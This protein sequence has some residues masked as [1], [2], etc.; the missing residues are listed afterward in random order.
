MSQPDK[1]IPLKGLRG[2]IANNMMSSLQQ[3]AQLS[4]MTDV[5]IDPLLNFRKFYKDKGI[6]IGVED[7]LLKCVSQSL[8]SFP[9][10]NGTVEQGEIRLKENQAISIATPIAGGL[11]APK[12]NNI[13]LLSLEEISSQRRDL[14]SRA[15]N[16]QLK[17]SE[18]TGGTFTISN[19]GQ[20]RVTHFTPIV[21][22]PQI[23]ILGIGTIKKQLKLDEKG[24]CVEYNTMGLSLTCDH[25]AVDGKP[26][27]DFLTHLAEV[28][29][30]LNQ[31]SFI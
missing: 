9:M 3:S 13:N 25:R 8:A 4:F 12:I 19:L 30:Q 14:I 31:G 21:N 29:E 7:V 2:M 1:I 15:H 5:A 18:M 17:P 27:G 24:A 16:N 23:A 6:A 26:A 11:A 28:I 10:F 22:P 20:T